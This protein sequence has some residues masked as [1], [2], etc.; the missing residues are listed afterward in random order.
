MEKKQLYE[1][2]EDGYEPFLPVTE[3]DDVHAATQKYV[4]FRYKK[5]LNATDMPSGF[6]KTSRTAGDGWTTTPDAVMGNESLWMTQA[7]IDTDNSLLDEWTTPVR[8]SGSN[9][10]GGEPGERGANG[11]DGFTVTVTPTPI[12]LDTDKK[13]NVIYTA[14]TATITAHYGNKRATIK[15]DKLVETN[16]TG[17]ISDNKSES[18]KITITDIENIAYNLTDGTTTVFAA[19]CGSVKCSATLSCDGKTRDVTITIPFVVNIQ[20]YNASFYADDMIWKNVMTSNLNGKVSQSVFEQTAEHILEKVQDN[21]GNIATLEVRADGVEA[22]VAQN[23]QYIADIQVTAT[24][25]R[26]EYTDK[27][28]GC[29]SLIEQ[30]AEEFRLEVNDTI[31]GVQSSIKQVSDSIALEVKDRESAISTL[32]VRVDGIEQRVTNNEGDIGNLKVRAD[33]VEATVSDHGNR[34]GDLEVTA[35]SITASI[36]N[37]S[38]DTN[39]KF[40]TLKADIDGL[41][42]RVG[43]YKTDLEGKISSHYTE[44]QQTANGF[45]SRISSVESK[46]TTLEGQASTLEANVASLEATSQQMSVSY[47]NGV[48]RKINLLQRSYIRY[49]NEGKSTV[50][51]A[52]LTA[53]TT[54]TLSAAALCL[55]LNGYTAVAVKIVCGSWSRSLEFSYDSTLESPASKS[56]TFTAT[57]SDTYSV[58]AVPIDVSSGSETTTY[59]AYRLEWLCLVKGDSAPLGWIPHT[60]DPDS[61]GNML[62]G[63]EVAENET[64]IT[65]P[66]GAKGKKYVH[67]DNT[68]GS[69]AWEDLKVAVDLEAGETYTLSFW[70][71]GAGN[72]LTRF[73]TYNSIAWSLCDQKSNAY[74]S[75]GR[76]QTTIALTSEWTFYEITFTVASTV[77]TRL[78]LA[79]V[80]SGAEMYMYDWKLE[81]NGRWSGH[82]AEDAEKLAQKNID[83]LKASVNSS[84]NTLTSSLGALQ[85][86]TDTMSA[87]VVYQDDKKY[88]AIAGSFDDKGNLTNTS[89]LVATPTAAGIFTS[90]KQNDGTF[91]TAIIGTAVT[92]SGKTIVKLSGDEIR[93]EGEIS[94]NGNVSIGTDGTL[95]AKNGSFTGTVNATAGNIAGFTISGNGLVNTTFSDD[96]YL[97]MRN[98][99]HGCFAGIGGNIMPAENG[100]RAVARFENTD[101][102]N[103]WGLGRNVAMVLNAQNATYNHAFIGSGNGNLNGWIDG[104][105]FSKFTCTTANTIYDGYAKI[106]ENNRWIIYSSVSSSGIVLPKLTQVR[107]ALGIGK[108]TTFCIRFTVVCDI[109]S[110]NIL[111]YGRNKNTNSSKATPWNTTELPLII[112]QDGSNQDSYE[113]GAGDSLEFLL[114][115][116][117]GKSTTVNGYSEYYTARLISHLS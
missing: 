19:N 10:V 71:K 61:Y 56:V 4:E 22:R 112:H 34:I 2:T 39:Q 107:D 50:K 53:G 48:V 23:E 33:S 46:T 7:T 25:M 70:V 95:T 35:K 27:I 14:N 36:S 79:Y 9:G 59:H 42:T 90:V 37:L 49:V 77:S 32:S 62:L 69:N 97:I 109:G 78:S 16:C 21:Q 115:Y 60:D 66:N 106:S 108:T 76:G 73:T 72:M 100:I 52:A 58:Y 13:G 104:Y 41:S 31:T 94:A 65:L 89:G 101:S 44:F 6:D 68:S 43:N 18:V 113:M 45:E 57:S 54:Y 86:Q 11:E 64:A 75:N 82:N 8:I 26:S 20:A 51:T 117:S 105:K 93:L 84:V 110:K 24:E 3:E 80:Y 5:S 98:D 38:N 92:E 102:K 12:T 114:V 17:T 116:D 1:Q 88:A 55:D 30:T 40:T 91:K 67:V 103:W 111:V 83:T 29:N 63:M 47:A 99:T 85:T 74:N 15:I 81:H 28:S 96:A 87:T